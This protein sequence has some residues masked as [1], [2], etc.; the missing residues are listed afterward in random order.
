M[1]KI[2]VADFETGISDN[3]EEAWVYMAGLKEVGGNNVAIYYSIQSFVNALSDI[4][5]AQKQSIEVYFHNLSFD[6]SYLLSYL[7][8]S[9]ITSKKFNKG[10]VGFNYK[11]GK[12]CIFFKDTYPL[13][14]C[15][16]KKL[17][18]LFG[19]SK[20]DSE[21][22]Q[23]LPNSEQVIPE[24]EKQYLVRDVEILERCVIEIQRNNIDGSQAASY[25]LKEIKR[26]MA[27]Q[28]RS[29]S[30]IKAY[31]AGKISQLE[32]GTDVFDSRFN[33]LSWDDNEV[34]RDA[35]RSGFNVL[36]PRFENKIIDENIEDL[37]DIDIRL[38]KYLE[39]I[40]KKRQD[41]ANTVEIQFDINSLYLKVLRDFPMPYGG[42]VKRLWCDEAV[43]YLYSKDIKNKIAF[44]DCEIQV[45]KGFGVINPVADAFKDLMDDN[46]D[47]LWGRLLLPYNEFAILANSFGAVDRLEYTKGFEWLA[48]FEGQIEVLDISVSSVDVF[49]QAQGMFNKFVDKW[50]AI[51]HGPKNFMQLISKQVLT[52]T[53]GAM[54]R[55]GRIGLYS[56]V[57]KLENVDENGV[58]TVTWEIN[59][60]I[61]KQQLDKRAQY[62]PVPAMVTS[63]G[64]CITSWVALQCG[65]RFI[66]QD[67]DQVHVLIQGNFDFLFDSNIYN[68]ANRKGLLSEQDLGMFKIERM[69]QR[70][71]FLKKKT[72]IEED[73]AGE[74]FAV[75]AGIPDSKSKF[76]LDGEG[77][78][79]KFELGA[80]YKQMIP[81]DIKGGKGIWEET[82]EI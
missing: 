71:R 70:A 73:V 28:S 75:T 76:S 22:R 38:Q 43:S 25:G 53:V 18:E 64:R 46:N 39:S 67:T 63:I 48:D 1:S 45:S 56:I 15:S 61:N 3:R 79:T 59:K 80:K 30:R 41:I 35:Y 42:L 65:D 37:G 51:K 12:Y 26:S 4:V 6:G 29:S 13:V 34:I 21:Y 17:G 72:Y 32:L 23:Y 19:M 16:I 8:P 40:G 50:F 5:K 14:R 54:G 24:V 10:I 2:Y 82:R 44:V 68:L 74:E 27:E 7:N 52:N 11:C 77:D 33:K 47:V 31:K 36:N 78:R 9:K 81:H 55:K 60:N 62:T 57:N 69:V 49:Y 66:Y 20:L 58:G